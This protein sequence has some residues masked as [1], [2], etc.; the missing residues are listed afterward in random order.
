M[1]LHPVLA[2]R[3]EWAYADPRCEGLLRLVSGPRT[4][5]EQIVLWDGWQAR[6]DWARRHLGVMGWPNPYRHFNEAANPYV[7]FARAYD[8]V[9]P[10]EGS[11][12]MEQESEQYGPCGYAGDL[13]WSELP[14]RLWAP[15]ETVLFEARLIRTVPGEPWHWQMF[16]NDWTWVPSAPA[17]DPPTLTLGAAWFATQ[18]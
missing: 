18:E 4:K 8:L 2:A 1:R 13:N 9:G 5:Q 17:P 11:W 6:R 7:K 3:L 16:W 12:H 14:K 10:R 15:V